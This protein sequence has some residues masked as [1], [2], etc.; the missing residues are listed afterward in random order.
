LAAHQGG[1]DETVDGLVAGFAKRFSRKLV[2]DPK[3]S[4]ESTWRYFGVA[5]VA[6]RQTFQK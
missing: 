6:L 3:M 2:Q 5:S 1:A 4:I